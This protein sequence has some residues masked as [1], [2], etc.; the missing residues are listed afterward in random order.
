MAKVTINEDKLN[1]IIYEA[2]LAVLNEG[3]MDEWKW[4]KGAGFV[5]NIA[6][7][8]GYGVERLKQRA[9]DARTMFNVGRD[10]AQADYGNRNVRSDYFDDDKAFKRNL[11]A[12]G[13]RKDPTRRYNIT[14]KQNAERLGKTANTQAAAT[15]TGNTQ[16]T[17]AKAR[18]TQTAADRTANVQNTAPQQSNTAATQNTA[19]QQPPQSTFTKEQIQN[20]QNKLSRWR[21]TFSKTDMNLL[22]TALG[23]YAT[24][25]NLNESVINKAIPMIIK[26]WGKK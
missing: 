17:T 10:E 15:E 16:T 7:N 25:H 5:N 19:P 18:K 3:D 6:Q 20:L 4:T 11:D 2:T 13:Q 14:S 22:V 23:E 21:K 24:S 8:V 12:S 1:Q 9:N 26:E